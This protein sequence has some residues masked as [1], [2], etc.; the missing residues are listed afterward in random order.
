[1]KGGEHL[2]VQSALPAQPV[3][4][5]VDLLAHGLA[6][7]LVE[8]ALPLG[9]IGLHIRRR[10]AA[11]ERQNAAGTRDVVTVRLL[12]AQVFRRQLPEGDG[13][14]PEQAGEAEVQLL[15][16]KAVKG[17]EA[18]AKRVVGAAALVCVKQDE[19]RVAAEREHRGL[20]A[21]RGEQLLEHV[22][23]AVE[24]EAVF[25]RLALPM[26]DLHPHAAAERFR[27]AGE[28]EGAGLFRRLLRAA[29]MPS[30]NSRRMLRL[31]PS[32]SCAAPR[33]IVL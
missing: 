14:A 32:A 12:Q 21:H 23:K 19:V 17:F 18:A 6:A 13:A 4:V 10:R 2:P 31:K 22:L 29:R 26:L 33:P 11:F 5:C 28:A 20:P 1:M 24:Q 9:E 30:R 3:E 8:Q 25:H 27:H 15:L 7:A 16:R